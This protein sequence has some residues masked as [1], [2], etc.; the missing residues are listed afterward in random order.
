MSGRRI[1]ITGGAGYLGSALVDALAPRL[2]AG[3]FDV[4]VA[5]DVREVS[6][7]SRRAGVEYVVH[8][9]RTPGL[10]VLLASR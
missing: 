10:D 6:A 5:S 4:V 3:E 7:G 1:F 8:D 9:V 2:A